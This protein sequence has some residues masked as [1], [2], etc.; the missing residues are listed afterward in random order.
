MDD[1]FYDALLCEQGHVINAVATRGK[2]SPRDSACCTTCGCSSV[3]TC[4]GC[5]EYIRGVRKKHKHRLLGPPLPYPVSPGSYQPPAYCHQCGH[6][7]P[8]TQGGLKNAE[9][10]SADADKKRRR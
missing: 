7:Y 8:W 1:E 9:S 5:K 4:G 3:R 6:S 2:P 10:F